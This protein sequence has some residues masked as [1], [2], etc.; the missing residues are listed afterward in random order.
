MPCPYLNI[1]NNAVTSGA[2]SCHGHG[3]NIS[4]AA[5]GAHNHTISG[6]TDTTGS[7]TTGNNE[8]QYMNVRYLIRVK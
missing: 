5:S 2:G 3:D 7:G 4:Y 6:S 1:C 8:P